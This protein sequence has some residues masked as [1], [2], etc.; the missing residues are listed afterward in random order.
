MKILH[1]NKKIDLKATVYEGNKTFSI[2]EKGIETLDKGEVRIKVAYSG[3]CGTDVH[4]YH[5]II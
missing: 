5:G 3:V 4:I 2:I 1:Y